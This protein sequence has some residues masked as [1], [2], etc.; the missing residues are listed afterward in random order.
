MKKHKETWGD[1]SWHE[2]ARDMNTNGQNMLEMMFRKFRAM[3]PNPNPK[4][5]VL[6]FIKFM[7][8]KNPSQD[9]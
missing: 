5:T 2:E 4:P 8:T 7:F 9:L 6:S 3:D 1:M